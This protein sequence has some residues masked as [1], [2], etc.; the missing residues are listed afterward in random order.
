MIRWLKSMLAILSRSLFSSNSQISKPKDHNWCLRRSRYSCS[1]IRVKRRIVSCSHTRV[2][3]KNSIIKYRKLY[4]SKRLS[5]SK[6]K[7]WSRR[8]LKGWNLNKRIWTKEKFSC[9]KIMT[10]L[11]NNLSSL[12]SKKT[13]YKSKKWNS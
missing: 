13:I 10:S 1:W 12:I 6:R 11:T 2:D 7:S 5:S 8:R 3:F 4:K 9:T